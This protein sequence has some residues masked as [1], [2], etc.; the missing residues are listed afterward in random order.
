MGNKLNDLTEAP[1]RMIGDA[2]GKL[3]WF[4]GK[5]KPKASPFA[6]VR[7][8]A[9]RAA[10]VASVVLTGWEIYEFIRATGGERDSSPS[11]RSGSSSSSKSNAKKSGEALHRGEED[12]RVV[13][14]EVERVVPLPDEG[15]VTM[16]GKLFRF[17]IGFAIGYLV[18]V[19][20]RADENDPVIRGIKRADEGVRRA[21]SKL[22]S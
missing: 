1:V 9:D 14:E 6:L 11:S 17:R 16:L 20:R 12:L 10:T 7:K 21:T 8:V 22:T 18:A 4:G 13:R 15:G 3:P 5:K 19:I 2:V